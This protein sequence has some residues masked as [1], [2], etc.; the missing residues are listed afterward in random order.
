MGMTTE[1]RPVTAIP[2]QKRGGSRLPVKTNAAEGGLFLALLH[3][4]HQ[5]APAEAPAA[6]LPQA[7]A[8]MVYPLVYPRARTVNYVDVKA[9]THDSRLLQYIA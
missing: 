8:P 3:T 5:D 4:L 9:L 2:K 7:P 6:P 1:V